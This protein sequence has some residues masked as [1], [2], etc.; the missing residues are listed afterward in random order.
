MH[1]A[2]TVTSASHLKAFCKFFRDTVAPCHV[3][4]SFDTYLEFTK[5]E[6]GT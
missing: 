6:V 4:V 3:R 1:E 2:V 5:N